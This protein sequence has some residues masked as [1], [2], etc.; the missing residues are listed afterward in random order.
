MQLMCCECEIYMNVTVIILY[1]CVY[2]GVSYTTTTTAIF[3]VLKNEAPPLERTAFLR[4]VHE[5]L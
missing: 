1:E 5:P 2:I 4:A 3:K